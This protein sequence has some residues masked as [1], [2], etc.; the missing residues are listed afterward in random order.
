MSWTRRG[1]AATRMNNT[2]IVVKWSRV[3]HRFLSS[4]ISNENAATLS[5]SSY[6]PKLGVRLM[7][8]ECL[9]L[10][11]VFAGGATRTIEVGFD[12]IAEPFMKII[13]FNADLRE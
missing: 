10:D 7:G 2:G 4:P 1:P 3:A 8:A 6:F 5:S 9:P 13:D 11:E 12:I